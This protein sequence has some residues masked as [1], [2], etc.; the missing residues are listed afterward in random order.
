MQSGYKKPFAE[1]VGLVEPLILLNR[2]YPQGSL[3]WLK[4][5]FF[6]DKPAETNFFLEPLPFT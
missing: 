2:L 3:S 1:Q 5:V 6:Q 4:R